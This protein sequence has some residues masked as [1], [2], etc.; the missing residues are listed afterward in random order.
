[1]L[2]YV[3]EIAALEPDP[4]RINGLATR[5]AGTVTAPAPAPVP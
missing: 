1:V 3:R 4:A 2:R 5:L